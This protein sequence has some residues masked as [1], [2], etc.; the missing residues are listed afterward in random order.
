MSEGEGM[1]REGEGE[2]GKEG[3]KD[4]VRNKE[5]RGKGKEEQERRAERLVM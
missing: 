2:E 4:I 1:N 3:G 5:G